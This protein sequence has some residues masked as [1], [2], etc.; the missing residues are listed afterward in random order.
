MGLKNWFRFG[1]KRTVMEL[2]K[3]DDA[4]LK[5]L[6]INETANAKEA[7]YFTCLRI[8]SDSVSKISLEIIE[9]NGDGI[10]KHYGHK[11]EK[12][13]NLK[14]NPYMSANDF[15]KAVEHQRN[16]Q[17]NAVV[18]PFFNARTGVLEHL[19]PVDFKNV[20]L[21]IDNKGILGD[22]DQFYYIIKDKLGNRYKYH[23][24]DVLHFKGVTYDGMIGVP[25][26]VVLASL[27]EGNKGAQDYVKN[28]M[29]NGMFG[30]GTIQYTGDISDNSAKNLAEKLFEN[31]KSVRNAGKIFPMPV[32]FQ[33]QPMKLTMADA[34]FLELSQLS[35]RQI[36][37]AFGIKLH[38]V[39]DLSKSSFSSISEQNREFY[40]DTLLAIF[41]MYECEMSYK[42]FHDHEID[43][44]FRVKFSVDNIL[45]ADIK[46]RYE[47][48]RIAIN[49]GFKTPNE[50][51]KLEGDPAVPEG[52][53]LICNGNMQKVRDIGVFY[54]N[55]E[56]K[57]GGKGKDE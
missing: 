24:D 39:N 2:N 45:R 20:E 42:L 33:Y 53:D 26:K 7:T 54:K 29:E 38:Q 35:V 32:G 50:C 41:K 13:L 47:A 6:G 34:Q 10:K 48:Y 9:R 12:I 37:G 56:G 55:K 46:T 31:V 43:K 44:G 11:L 17:G 4:I 18:L 28:F 30:S 21:W 51:R 1:N 16:D 40:I 3:D 15:W 52:D 23:P 22:P 8:L 19:Y 49:A 5:A 57:S 25:V 27:I 14:P 36:A